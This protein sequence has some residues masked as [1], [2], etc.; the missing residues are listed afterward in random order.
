MCR[1]PTIFRWRRPSS[2]FQQF[3]TPPTS[4]PNNNNS[5]C[6]LTFPYPLVLVTPAMNDTPEMNEPAS[7]VA[8]AAST[9]QRKVPVAEKESESWLETGKNL[10]SSF[11]VVL[12]LCFLVFH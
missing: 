11:F 10:L 9:D 1:S 4:C 12:C 6:S 2:L 3:Q 5:A 7:P 8:P